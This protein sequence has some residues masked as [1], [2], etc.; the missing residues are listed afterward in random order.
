MRRL[1][2]VALGLTL[3]VGCYHHRAAAADLAPA[4]ESRS[5]MLWS[6]VWGALQQELQPD[7]C[8]KAALQQVTVSSNFAFALLTVV[9]LGF[10]SPVTVEWRCAKDPVVPASHL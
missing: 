9:T 2:V 4:T 1:A 10:A 3:A 7:N 8:P 5:V 6:F